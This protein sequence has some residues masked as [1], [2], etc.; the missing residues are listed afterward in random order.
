MSAKDSGFIIKGKRIYLQELGLSDAESL[1][2]NIKD[3]EVLKFTDVPQSFSLKDA[4]KLI[5]KSKR[6][7]KKRKGYQLGIKSRRGQDV[8]GVIGLTE[9][10]HKNKKA[11]LDYWLNKKYRRLGIMKEAISLIVTFGFR[12]L[13]LRRIYA[14]VLT[15]NMPSW[16]LLTAMGFTREGVL[17]K[18]LFER[19]RW[20][21]LFI[22]SLLREEFI[23]NIRG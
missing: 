16:K 3:K 6:D 11:E 21:D 1:Y 17:R 12:K 22:Y 20:H 9:I 4:F 19:R 2:K 5:K 18:G 8:I 7:I 13:K 23:K 15:E 10:D 14:R